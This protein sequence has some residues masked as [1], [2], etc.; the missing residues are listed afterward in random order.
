MEVGVLYQGQKIRFELEFGATCVVHEGDRLFV[1]NK[2]QL[3]TITRA[4]SNAL[5][6]STYRDIL[7]RTLPNVPEEYLNDA[8][9]HM[10][11]YLDR[12]PL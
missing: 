8:L 1:V 11:V 7:K 2:D 3:N 9:K 12:E 10:I 6:A 5:L 4:K